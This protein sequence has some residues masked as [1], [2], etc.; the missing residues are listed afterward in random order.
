[1]AVTIAL[2][3]DST[4]I[5]F[6]INNFVARTRFDGCLPA[7]SAASFVAWAYARLYVLTVQ[8]FLP[9]MTEKKPFLEDKSAFQKTCFAIMAVYLV[10]RSIF[11]SFVMIRNT[12][13]CKSADF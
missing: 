10:G 5:L 11:G 4:D 3:H 12:M 1:V 6:S 7:V 9:I 2:I 13:N 8:V